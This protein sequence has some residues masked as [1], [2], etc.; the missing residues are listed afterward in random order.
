MKSPV[1]VLLG[2]PVT[3]I[4]DDAFSGCSDLVTIHGN[5]MSRSDNQNN[6]IPNHITRIGARAFKGCSGLHGLVINEEVISIGQEC[7]A[8]CSSLE[9]LTIPFIG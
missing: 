3:A 6:S 9:E 5:T 7:F 8:E 2:K 1:A 4:G